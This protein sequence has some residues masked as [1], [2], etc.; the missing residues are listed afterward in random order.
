MSDSIVYVKNQNV[1]SCNCII[2]LESLKNKFTLKALN[3]DIDKNLIETM[4]QQ[5]V[6]NEK[7]NDKIK[8]LETKNKIVR[9]H[10]TNKHKLIDSLLQ[11]NFSNSSKF[12]RTLQS[13]LVFARLLVLLQILSFSNTF[14]PFQMKIFLCQPT[15]VASN[16]S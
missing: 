5:K 2:R 8:L 9:D 14:K 1:K 13:L 10:I 7:L 6:E 12:F 16:I 11:H 4:N 3:L 15:M